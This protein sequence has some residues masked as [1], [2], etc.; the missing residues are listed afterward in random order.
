MNMILM[1]T[2]AV[3][4]ETAY[5]V[6]SKQTSRRK[7]ADVPTREKVREGDVTSVIVDVMLE[8]I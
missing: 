3:N 2:H 1:C 6:F 8:G 4:I 5:V 7:A